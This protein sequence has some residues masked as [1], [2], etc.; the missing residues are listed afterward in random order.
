MNS[1]ELDI[2]LVN[3]VCH[4]RDFTYPGD[5]GPGRP[6]VPIMSFHLIGQW[7]DYL[8]RLQIND[9]RVPQF[10]V[11]EYHAALRVLLFA[12]IEPAVIKPAELQA[13]RSLEGTL[14]DIYF[15]PIYKMKQ[16]QNP[17]LKREDFAKKLG[18][19]KL[20]DYMV[21]HD[22]LPPLLHSELKRSNKS[23]LDTIRNTAFHGEPFNTMPWGGLF[24]SVREVIIHACRNRPLPE[25]YLSIAALSD[26]Q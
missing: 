8:L 11:N 26:D 16:N 19:G 15:E 20:L 25:N 3:P 17:T 24:E 10:H 13:L 5:F 12:W 6:N 4:E 2:S 18:L 14:R 1:L 23:A 9:Q 22:D 21:E 7:R